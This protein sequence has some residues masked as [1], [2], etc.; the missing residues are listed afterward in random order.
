VLGLSACGTPYEAQE[1]S[2]EVS[3]PVIGGQTSQPNAWPWHVEVRILG[4]Y[5]CGGSLIDRDWVLTAA[6]CV[7][8]LSAASVSIVAGSQ[9]I[10]VAE[11]SEQTLNV[12]S[13][14]VHTSYDSGQLTNDIALLK[15]ASPVTLNPHR[16]LIKIAKSDD[17][18]GQSGTLRGWGAVLPATG[19]AFPLLQQ[20]ELPIKSNTSCDD[21]L[22]LFRNLNGNELCAGFVDGAKAG[23]HGDSGSSF[24]IVGNDGRWEQA[25]IDSWGHPDC[26]TYTVFSRVSSHVSW[27]QSH[28]TSRKD[29]PLVGDL[30]GDGRKELVIWRPGVGTFRQ[31]PSRWYV[32]R[33][34]LTFFYPYGTE[35]DWG[36]GTDVPLLGD[37][38]A[39][40]S[41]ELVAWRPSD[42]RWYALKAD[43]TRL[44]TAGAEPV[45]GSPNDVPFL[46][47]LDGDNKKDPVVWRPSTGKWYGRLSNGALAFPGGE[48]LLGASGDVPLVGDLDNDGKDDL[49]V[50]RPT[51]GKWTAMRSNGVRIFTLGSEP[52][53]GAMGDIPIVGDLDGDFVDDMV[54]YQS[55]EGLWNGV[56]TNGTQIFATGSAP[57]MGTRGDFP[58][59]ANVDQGSN[60]IVRWRPA[61]ARWFAKKT[62]GTVIF[63]DVWWGLPY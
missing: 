14:V 1:K 33:S 19:S 11:P 31:T 29:V 37:M 41:D 61:D 36:Y 13:I 5:Q 4:H 34:D 59:L 15:L 48:L 10:T 44:F 8:F 35:P 56:R 23:C 21:A 47:D 30:N 2:G 3:S 40:G 53:W 39:D 49:I 51:D 38:N 63:S 32:L 45:L 20:A 55:S 57:R 27:I 9:D 52:R 50:W 42:G 16:Q 60:D 46:A 12:A 18:P 25:G 62:N 6:H 43:K 26:T 22:G 28:V 54:A 17:G 58:F 7:D 24:A